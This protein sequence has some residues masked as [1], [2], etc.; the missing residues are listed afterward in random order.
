MRRFLGIIAMI[1]MLTAL[2]PGCGTVEEP[3]APEEPAGLPEKIF[4]IQDYP[5]CDGAALTL[6]MSEAVCAALTG[7]E[8]INVHNKIIHNG[9]DKALEN[10]FSS[11]A[12]II[13]V[14]K[15]EEKIKKAAENAGVD[16]EIVPVAREY[17]VFYTIEEDEDETAEET[18]D[19]TA[20][21]TENDKLPGIT[22]EEA[23]SVLL[24]TSS[25]NTKYEYGYFLSGYVPE[26]IQIITVDGI[27]PSAAAVESGE[28]TFTLHYNA[29]IRA[30]SPADSGERKIIAAM[31]D[32]KGQY[33]LEEA[34]YVKL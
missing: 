16:V 11:K 32:E 21:D 13:F 19:N 22:A 26:R 24:G 8:I 23:N 3:E 31:L 2:I 28:Y 27:Y 34:G 4:E 9:S 25:S 30:D 17:Y 6:P 5:K 12:D 29:V 10:L 33:L 14:E 15:S 7:E 18:D 20:A 1:V